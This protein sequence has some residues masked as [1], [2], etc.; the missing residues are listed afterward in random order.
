MTW[1]SRP[2]RNL[3]KFHLILPPSRPF[4]S[5]LSQVNSGWASLPLTSILANIGKVTP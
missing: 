4:F 3:V 1:P 5:P 2:T